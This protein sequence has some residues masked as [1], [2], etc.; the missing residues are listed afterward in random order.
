LQNCLGKA[1]DEFPA[2]DE[3]TELNELA[4]LTTLSTAFIAIISWTSFSD[5]CVAGI[6]AIGGVEAVV[7]GMQ[8]FPECHALQSRVLRP[9]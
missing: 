1:I 2:C 4:E 3:V 8:S 7:E 6:T 5:K 9:T